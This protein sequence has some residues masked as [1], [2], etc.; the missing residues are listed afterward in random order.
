ML[1]L[2]F[3]EYSKI[4]INYIDISVAAQGW[5]YEWNFQKIA[6]YFKI[7]GGL[8]SSKLFWSLAL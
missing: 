7:T 6:A 8:K 1:A 2:S 5:S 3:D 4:F